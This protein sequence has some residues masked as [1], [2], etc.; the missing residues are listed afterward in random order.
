MFSLKKTVSLAKE[1]KNEDRR[2]IMVALLL[3]L[4]QARGK[5][6]TFKKA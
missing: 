1:K 3:F 2:K 6:S 5:T 4:K